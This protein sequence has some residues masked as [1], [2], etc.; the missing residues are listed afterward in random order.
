MTRDENRQKRMK[1][2]Q[3]GRR[4]IGVSRL[5]GERREEGA[6]ETQNPGEESG[7]V[8]LR[9]AGWD[10]GGNRGCA[11][12]DKGKDDGPFSFGNGIW[13]ENEY[14][15]AYQVDDSIEN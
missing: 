12:R 13:V 6:R 7:S 15:N 14:R 1:N 11:E 10:D 3:I 9:F 5:E 4:K 8:S 2:L